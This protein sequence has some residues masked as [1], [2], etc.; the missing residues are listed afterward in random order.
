MPTVMKLLLG[1]GLT[2][3]VALVVAYP[4]YLLFR[5]KSQIDEVSS[6]I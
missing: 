4:V 6:A 3:L 5:N 2:R 1:C